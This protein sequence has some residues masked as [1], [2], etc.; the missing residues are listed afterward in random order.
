MIVA[1]A[2]HTSNILAGG[3]SF[4]PRGKAS[5]MTLAIVYLG[6]TSLSVVFPM[7]QSPSL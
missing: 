5:G 2:D 4:H 7:S 1:K 6:P 3:K